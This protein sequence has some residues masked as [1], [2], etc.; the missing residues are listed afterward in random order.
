MSCPLL[1]FF[2]LLGST[3]LLLLLLYFIPVPDLGKRAPEWL[4]PGPAFHDTDGTHPDRS[5]QHYNFEPNLLP[6]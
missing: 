5:R 3:V 2:I 4:L 1:I 6:N